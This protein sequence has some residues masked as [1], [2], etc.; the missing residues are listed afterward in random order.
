HATDPETVTVTFTMPENHYYMYIYSDEHNL[1][2]YRT[3]QSLTLEVE[4]G[5]VLTEEDVEPFT[6]HCPDNHGN[7]HKYCRVTMTGWD[8]DPV[9]MEIT[10]DTEFFAQMS[11]DACTVT[12]RMDEGCYVAGSDRYES[13]DVE[14]DKGYTITEDDVRRFST[15]HQYLDTMGGGPT[16]DIVGLTPEPLGM[17]VEE[18]ITIIANA[19]TRIYLEYYLPDFE[20]GEYYTF[21]G[22]PN[23]FAYRGE[24]YPREELMDIDSALE[25]K[26]LDVIEAYWDVTD[27]Q[28]SAV[29]ATS[30]G[31]FEIYGKVTL[32]GD[33]NQD[34]L[35]NTAD[36]VAVLRYAA[37]LHTFTEVQEKAADTNKDGKVNTADAVLMLQYAAG[38]SEQS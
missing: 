16:Y 11:E 10:E 35:R 14:V 32:R 21:I 23:H 5:H 18:D 31:C 27:E 1:G 28:L 22:W 30:L 38:I 3:A 29:Y 20:T 2:E 7:I 15:A 19:K 17:V 26:N 9:G 33:C 24:P 13:F 25:S 12:V 8:R 6:V 37:K 34:I 36:A 4:K